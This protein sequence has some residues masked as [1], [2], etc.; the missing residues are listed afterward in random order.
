[1]L[2]YARVQLLT[3][4]MA[5]KYAFSR[6]TIFYIN[7]LLPAG[8]AM[9]GRLTGK[10][11][12]YHYHEN[13][14]VKGTFY[15]T[16][17][18][19]MQKLATRIICVSNYQASF[20]HRK[21]GVEVVPNELDKE[22]VAKLRPDI[23]AAFERK[24]VL[25]LSSL[26]GYKG[27]KEFIGLANAL[28]EYRFTLVVNDTQAAIDNWLKR[29][30]P[31]MPD[32]LTIHSRAKDVTIFYNDASIVMNLSNPDLF[33]ETFGLTA[34]E[35]GACSLP[36]IVPTVGGI[37]ELVEDGVNGYKIDCRDTERLILAIRSLL[38]NKELYRS[39]ASRNV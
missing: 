11:V 39:I 21:E 33:V 35:A 29:E 4:F 6:N 38:S 30:N 20:L 12:I 17:A 3:F 16:L 22:F 32:N 31:D 37:A 36:V 10:R 28:P 8:P 7:T 27:T 9:A 2:R 25:M 24:N 23:E 14:F 19:L 13:A 18:W 15:R 34:L 1:M 5:L 26:K